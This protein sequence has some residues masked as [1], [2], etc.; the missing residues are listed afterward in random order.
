VSGWLETYRGIVYRWEVDHNDHLTVAFYFARLS[1]AAHG[2]L[3]A[4]GLGLEYARRRGGLCLTTDCYVRYQR[5]LRV[6]DIMHITSGVLGVERDGLVLGHKV[7]NSETGEVCTSVEQRLRHVDARRR[8]IHAAA[9]LPVRRLIGTHFGAPENRHHDQPPI[10]DLVIADD[11]VPVVSRFASAAESFE[12]GVGRHRAVE[13][14]A[15]GLVLFSLLR[16]NREARVDHLDDV[17][18]PDGET[19]VGGIAAAVSAMRTDEARAQAV[20]TFNERGR[21]LRAYLALLDGVRR[22]ALMVPRGDRERRD[23]NDGRSHADGTQSGH[24]G[25]VTRLASRLDDC[26]SG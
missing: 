19:V 10:R 4:L 22:S 16:K 14:L 2:L 1:D 24:A 13:N 8:Q 9:G 26:A 3:N 15:A 18:W 11:G 23:A 17:V 21:G 12:D 7:F 20:K 5:E 6:G 25:K